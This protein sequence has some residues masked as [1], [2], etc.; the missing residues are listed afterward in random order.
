MLSESE[1]ESSDRLFLQPTPRAKLL[2]H[3]PLRRYSSSCSEG[4]KAD[5]N[6]LMR[7]T[8][9]VDD[10]SVAP[11]TIAARSSAVGKQHR[12]FSVDLGRV[13]GSIS[14][15]KSSMRSTESRGLYSSRKPPSSN[16]FVSSCPSA[17]NQL[18]QRRYVSTLYL[19]TSPLVGENMKVSGCVLVTTFRFLSI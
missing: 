10:E 1:A 3:K 11:P 16:G 15:T 13:Q 6:L 17:L 12:T 8:L 18:E 9:Q 5:E 19:P 2:I 4:L 14:A 7:E